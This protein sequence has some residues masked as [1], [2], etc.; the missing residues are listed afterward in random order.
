M[1][2]ILQGKVALVTGG[3]GGI[4]RASAIAL[5]QAGARV[6]VCGRRE[7]EGAETVKLIADAGG[8]GYFV[9]AD[10]ASADDVKSLVAEV[11]G[12][13]GTL[14]IAFNNAGVEG[15]LGLLA[16]LQEEDFDRVFAINVRGLWLCMKYQIQQFLAQGTGGVIINN[17]SVQGHITWG[18][19]GHYTASKHAVE[20]Y[21]KCAAIDY[22]KKGIRVNAIAPAVVKT[23][24]MT[25][26]F[27]EDDPAA[28]HLLKL[29]PLGRFADMDEIAGAV[30]FLA[31]DAASYINGVSLPVDGGLLAM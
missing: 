4:G 29:H 8:E 13:F 30:V 19:S 14:D 28:R 10:V 15:G 12:R 11:V 23:D 3:T 20:G 17:S 2:K 1:S 9:R 26:T 18:F 5:A 6:A 7:G 22:A 31:S 27:A 24:L 16:D 21:T 25:Q